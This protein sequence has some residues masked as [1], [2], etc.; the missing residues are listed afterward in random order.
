VSAEGK[1]MNELGINI[2]YSLIGNKIGLEHMKEL[3]PLLRSNTA[4][5]EIK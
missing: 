1:E 4:L 2:L 5:R 3:A